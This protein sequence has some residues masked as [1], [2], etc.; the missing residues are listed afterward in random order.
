LTIVRA[1]FGKTNF[2]SGNSGGVQ[3]N[4][5]DD[6]PLKKENFQPSQNMQHLMSLLTCHSEV[7]A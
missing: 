4:N 2:N 6:S 3:R 5:F 7:M 1:V